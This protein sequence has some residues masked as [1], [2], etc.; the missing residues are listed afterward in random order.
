MREP[1][2]LLIMLSA[3]TC[4]LCA[5]PDYFV[6]AVAGDDANA[7]RSPAGAWKTLAPVNALQLEPGSRILLRAGGEYEGPLNLTGSGLPGQPNV[8]TRY[9]QGAKPHIRGGP[10][11]GPVVSLFNGSHWEIAD[12][13]ISGGTTGVFAYAKE[14]GIARDLRFLRLDIHDIAGGLTGDDGGFLLKREGED[15][16][17]EDLLIEGCTIQRADRNGILLTDY[18]TA[19][20]TYHS[21]GVVIRGNS[22]RDI[23]GDGI[24]IL[25]CDG[26]VIE[27]NVLRYAHQRVGR[28]PGERACAGI[29]PH[30]CNDTLI[31]FNEVS[32]TAVGG[33]TVWDSQ[34]FDDDVSCRGTVFQ[35]NYSHHNAGGFLLLCAGSRGTVARYNVSQN[36]AVATFTLES[37]GTGDVT[38]HNNAIHVG[39]G[40]AV[41]LFRNT[42]GAP[43]GLRFFN[44]VLH[45]E[46]R[47]VHSPRAITGIDCR[48]NAWFGEI[49]NRPGDPAAILA[50][51]GLAAPGTGA[52]GF[53]SLGGY[54]L[55]PDSPCRGAGVEVPGDPGIDLFGN[56]RPEGAAPWVGVQNR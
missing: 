20:D 5:A 1:W 6:D 33:V 21:R 56:A 28:R 4:P 50:A 45:V 19:K 27:H 18:P 51:P 34:A 47:M 25:G 46:G 39:E 11:S 10:G 40:L 15:T 52:E 8:L 29:W 49:G 53:G 43:D 48:N 30:R 31:Q 14:F 24:F 16:Y 17:F 23:G 36:D 26:A 2:C 42:F 37:D 54:R 32:H 9:G 35:F 41:T 13:E 3:I 44:N 55:S 38:I 12:L 22:L 7:G